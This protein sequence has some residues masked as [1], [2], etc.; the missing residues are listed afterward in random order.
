MDSTKSITQTPSKFLY[1]AYGSN[2]SEKRI[3]INNPSAVK[4]R[5][6]KLKDFRL[7]F[8]TQSKRW[9]GASATI[10]PTEDSHVWGVIWLLDNKDMPNLDE[11]EG[12]D[13][14]IYFP[15]TVE[16]EVPDLRDRP[17]KCRVYQQCTNPEEFQVLS[18]LPEERRPSQVYLNTIIQGAVENE[19][20]S[21]Y[22]EFLKTIA[23]NGY[24]GEVD[25]GLALNE[26]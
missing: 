20:P 18:Q 24:T 4:C 14:K 3:H 5:I 23:H 19:L 2:M 26:I 9:H 25:I 11:Q 12:V 8:N 6:G 22:I 7:D 10:I 13:Q 16:V 15:M 17:F 1:F 21:Y